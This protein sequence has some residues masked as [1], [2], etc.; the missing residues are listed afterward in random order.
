MEKKE[1]LVKELVERVRRGE[2]T[3]KEAEEEVKRIGL[4]HVK[5]EYKHWKGMGF[6][7]ISSILLCFLPFMARFTGLDA[8]RFFAGLPS[9]YFSDTVIYATVAVVLFLNVL[10]FYGLYLRTKKGGTR[11]EDEPIILLREGPYAIMR[12]PN[13]FAFTL[14]FPMFTVAASG[15]VPFTFLSIV[16]NILF[17]IGAFYLVTLGED[18]LNLLKW[19]DEYRRYMQEVPRFNFILGAWRWIKRRSARAS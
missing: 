1:D 16:G 2:I 13:G 10:G 12:H 19:G 5:Y 15:I 11:S 14:L 17:F 8:L 9:I 6:C 3:P 4:H 18:E 7:I